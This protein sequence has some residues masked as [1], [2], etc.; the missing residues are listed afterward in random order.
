MKVKVIVSDLQVP[1]HDK[2]AVA[3]VAKFIKAFKPDDVVSVGDEM[4]MQ[5]ISRWS[6]GTP[7]EY[8]RSIGRDRDAT[9]Q[10][11]EDLQVTHM[12][13]SNHTDRLYNTI[14][15]RA[16]GLLGAPEFELENFLRLKDLGIT[17]HKKPWEVAP[18]WL[19]LHGDEGSVNQTGGQTALGLAKKTGLSVVCGHTHRA[20]LLHYTESVSGVSTRTIWGLEVGNLMDQKKASYLKGGIA[21]WQQAIGMLYID[22]QKVT[23]KLIPIHKDGTFV[24]DGKVWGK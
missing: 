12:T 6:M 1:Y 14:M 19:L 3:N 13:R 10:V 4:D 17:Y 23:P 24:V 18:K 20:G 7:M 11:L 9:V 2:R 8:E 16:P 5:T 21:N 15:K 22:G